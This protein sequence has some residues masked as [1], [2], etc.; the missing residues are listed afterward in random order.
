MDAGNSSELSRRGLLLAGGTALLGGCRDV[1]SDREPPAGDGDGRASSTDADTASTARADEASGGTTVR[2]EA[3]GAEDW[4]AS[5]E[6]RTDKASH[7]A[8]GHVYNGWNVSV[9]VTS[10]DG[11]DEVVYVYEPVN[12]V[13]GPETIEGTVGTSPG[14]AMEDGPTL[15]QRGEEISIYAVKGDRRKLIAVHRVNS[16]YVAPWDGERGWSDEWRGERPSED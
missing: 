12:V 11:A 14:D 3:T 10:V 15:M 2:T 5:V 7:A 4:N 16:S 8:G 6:L 13:E 1:A 9:E